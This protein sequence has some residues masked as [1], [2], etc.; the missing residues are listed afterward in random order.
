MS[1]G[2][3]LARTEGGAGFAVGVECGITS[4][5]SGRGY[6]G[7]FKVRFSLAVVLVVAGRVVSV[8][9]PLSSAVRFCKLREPK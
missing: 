7:L 2:T 9:T 4:R 5:C 3:S 8:T 1:R 6:R